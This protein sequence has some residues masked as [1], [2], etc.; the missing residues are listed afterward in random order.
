M[1][2]AIANGK[3]LAAIEAASGGAVVGDIKYRA[4]TAITAGWLECDGSAVSR[5]TYAA[6]FAEIGVV[7]GVGDG[8]TTFNLPSLAR[9]T[10]RG[11]GGAGTGVLANT[12]GSV[13]GVETVAI[14][15]GE[16]PNHSHGGGNHNHDTSSDGQGNQI[17]QDNAP[18]GG[19]GG[20]QAMIYKTNSLINGV[21]RQTSNANAVSPE[22]GG[23]AHNNMAPSIIMLAL[24]KT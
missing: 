24:I 7:Y 17:Y 23:S 16:M 1:P 9:R 18:G 4:S 20:W 2:L 22:G 13:G 6:L 3:D 10:V 8:S 14:S 21:S 19:S 11:R 15:I 12:V 5:T